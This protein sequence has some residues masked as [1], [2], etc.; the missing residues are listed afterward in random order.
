VIPV[1]ALLLSAS[2]CLVDSIV[3]ARFDT[4]AVPAGLAP[5]RPAPPQQPVLQDDWFAEDKLRHFFM[6]LGATT[7]TYGALRA[8]G[9][10]GVL[11]R[12]GAAGAAGAAGLWK[13]WYD[14]R[15][16]GLFSLRDLVWDTLGIVAGTALIRNTR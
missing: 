2:C 3:P 14:H 1:L 6:S 10:D 4:A 12:A 8:A 16:G 7:L 5:P 11:G 9:I 13:E 15:Q